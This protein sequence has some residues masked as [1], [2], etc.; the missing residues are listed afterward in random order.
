MS[1]QLD[2]AMTV[3]RDEPS[4]GEIARA[5]ASGK[6]SALGVIDAALARIAKHAV[7][8]AQDGRRVVAPGVSPSV[9]G[10]CG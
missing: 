5:V 6:L 4:A 1:S 7:N 3:D 2:I 9:S 8:V 10:P